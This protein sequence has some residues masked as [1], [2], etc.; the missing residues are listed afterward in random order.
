MSSL[1]H[2]Q[3]ANIVHQAWQQVWGRAPTDRELAYAQAVAFLETGYGRIGQ[4]AQ[5]ADR[6][7]YQWGALERAQN[8]DGSCPPG[9][10][11]GVDQ[12]NVCFYVYSSDVAAA[13]AFL[14]TL[15][16]GKWPN[17]V[18]AM[19]TGSAVDVATAMYYPNGPGS[20][21]HYFAGSSGSDQDR[22]NTYAKAIGNALATAGYSN[23]P[24]GGASSSGGSLLVMG[25][26]GLAAGYAY[27]HYFGTPTWWHPGR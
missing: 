17:V 1:S 23:L 13:T 25:A 11:P 7:Q 5:M 24:A 22:I 15:T 14:K 12:G 18:N 26:L 2:A 8:A 10:A 21:P 6:G 20:T 4:F 19:N 9:T 27:V 3:A 16:R